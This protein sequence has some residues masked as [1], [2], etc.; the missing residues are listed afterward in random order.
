MPSVDWGYC[1]ITVYHRC[2]SPDIC[3]ISESQPINRILLYSTVDRDQCKDAGQASMPQTV[4]EGVVMC[5]Y[6][7]AI[8]G[9]FQVILDIKYNSKV[10]IT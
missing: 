9:L 1:S 6:L 7:Q 10:M 5:S 4:R 3:V 2:D 8:K